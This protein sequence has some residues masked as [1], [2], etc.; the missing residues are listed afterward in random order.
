M[1]FGADDNLDQGE[2]DGASGI[3]NG[4]SD[5]G[6]IRFVIDPAS[7]QAWVD[8]GMAGDT[9]YL[10]T[11][12]IPLVSFGTGECADGVCFSVHDR[13]AGRLPGRRRGGRTATPPTTRA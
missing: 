7:L 1:Y 12:P 5:G 8:A 13:A 4:P 6:A 10:Q 11:H 2:H 3:G 9:T